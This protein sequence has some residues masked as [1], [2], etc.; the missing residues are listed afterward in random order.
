[1]KRVFA[2]GTVVVL[3]S[4]LALFLWGG[5]KKAPLDLTIYFTA[6]ANAQLEPC[7]CFTG[8]YG[9]MARIKTYIESQSAL[10]TLRVDVGN[11]IGGAEDYEQIRYGYVQQAF[12]LLQYDVLNLGQRECQLAAS[13]ITALA[14]ES[15]IPLISANVLDAN[16]KPLLPAYHI[17]QRQGYR[18]AC[19]GIVDPQSVETPGEGITITPMAATLKSLL[20]TL[21]E[22]ADVLVLLAFTDQ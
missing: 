3:V 10:S 20:P 1:V 2:I 9:G 4:A 21:K 19:V 22:K 17:V 5:T 11:A 15:P 16:R 13:E 7:G 12:K 14:K 6:D 18:I 8:Q